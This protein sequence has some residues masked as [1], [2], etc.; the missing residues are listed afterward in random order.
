MFYVNRQDPALIVEKRFGFG[1]TLNF[2]HPAACF[3]LLRSSSPWES[4]QRSSLFSRRTHTSELRIPRG[5]VVLR[6]ST[7]TLAA[8]RPE[9]AQI[10]TK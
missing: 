6:A 3:C 1:Y 2:G 5:L 4:C 8:I 7:E 9:Q 10:Q